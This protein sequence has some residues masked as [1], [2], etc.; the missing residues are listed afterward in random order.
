MVVSWALWPVGVAI[1]LSS[2][3]YF[4]DIQDSLSLY[5]TMG[6]TFVVALVVL[7]PPSSCFRTGPIGRFAATATTGLTSLGPAE[8]SL[9]VQVLVI[10][11]GRRSG[12]LAASSVASVPAVWTV[13][14]IHHMPVR[15]N[16]LKAGRHH[17]FSFLLRGLIVWMPLLNTAA[18]D[19]VA[20]HRGPRHGQYRSRESTSGFR[21][22]CIASSSRRSFTVFIIPRMPGKVIRTTA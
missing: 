16:M 3:L 1:F 8:S 15:L 14:A 21:R 6:R 9:V 13:H 22:S 7:I 19:R 20:D 2:I 18:V 12:I 10:M 11:V 17:V 5:T 4:A